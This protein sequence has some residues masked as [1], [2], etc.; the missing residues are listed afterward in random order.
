MQRWEYLTLS[1]SK[2]YGTIKFFI[3]GEMQPA[4]KNGNFTQIINQIGGQ[5][6]EMVGISFDGAE[7]TYVF[8]RGAGKVATGQLQ[9]QAAA[10]SS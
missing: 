8:K 4:L 2:N 3:N 7:N 1:S 10:Q 9:E 6:W 5:G